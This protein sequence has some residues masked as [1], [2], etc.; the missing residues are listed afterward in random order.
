MAK[1]FKELQAKMPPGAH[2]KAKAEAEKIIQE[3]PLHELR[4]AR[5]L[6]QETPCE[7]PGHKPVRRFQNRAPD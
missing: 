7:N 1:N 4:A 3:M 2:A 5:L 6:T